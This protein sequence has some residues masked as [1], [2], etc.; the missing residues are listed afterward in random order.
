MA[1]APASHAALR[2]DLHDGPADNMT[3]SS[4]LAQ[5]PIAGSESVSSSD[6]ASGPGMDNPSSVILSTVDVT[7]A[8][9]ARSAAPSPARI[10]EA[11]AAHG[12]Y[13]KREHITKLRGIPLR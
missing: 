6:A 7:A 9:L 10:A 3:P 1:A 13:R 4:L 2:D 5:R 12:E 8:R 11:V